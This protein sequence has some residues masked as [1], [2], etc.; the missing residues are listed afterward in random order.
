MGAC[1]VAHL[2]DVGSGCVLSSEEVSQVVLAA[3]EVHTLS[4]HRLPSHRLRMDE[5]TDIKST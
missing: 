1:L 4:S 3:H 2:E 5:W